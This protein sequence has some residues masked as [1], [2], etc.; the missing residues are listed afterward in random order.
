MKCDIQH[1]LHKYNSN[2]EVFLDSCSGKDIFNTKLYHL[3]VNK[4]GGY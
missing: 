2:T 4:P 1:R 3:V